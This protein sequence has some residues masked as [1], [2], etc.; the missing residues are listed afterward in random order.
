MSIRQPWAELVAEN[1]RGKRDSLKWHFDRPRRVERGRVA[2][3]AGKLKDMKDKTP[4]GVRPGGILG[5]LLQVW[6]GMLR[7]P[8]DKLVELL[9]HETERRTCR[10][11]SPD[12]AKNFLRFLKAYTPRQISEDS[13]QISTDDEGPNRFEQ[14]DWVEVDGDR[15]PVPSG[16]L[17]G[18][19]GPRLWQD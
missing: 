1:V 15:L 3:A 17:A 9:G 7:N 2:D 16:A 13:V 14:V 10:A 18:R 6:N 12:D 11:V 4:E 19:R 5:P 8:P